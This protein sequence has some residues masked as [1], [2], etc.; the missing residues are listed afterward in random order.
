MKYY[1]WG[2]FIVSLDYIKDDQPQEGKSS[3]KSSNDKIILSITN[4]YC[5]D[6]FSAIIT[7]KDIESYSIISS[8][9]VLYNLIINRLKNPNKGYQFLKIHLHGKYYRTNPSI[10]VS[11]LIDTPDNKCIIYEITAPE[12][13]PTCNINILRKIV[14]WQTRN[15]NV[16]ARFNKY[17]QIN[18]ITNV[19]D[20]KDI[21]LKRKLNHK[22]KYE[23]SIYE[24]LGWGLTELFII[25]VHVAKDRITF[26]S[27]NTAYKPRFGNSI[28]KSFEPRYC[29]FMLNYLYNLEEVTIEDIWN[30]QDLNFLPLNN[31][32]KSLILID[33]FKLRDISSLCNLSK[34][35]RLIIDNSHEISSHQLKK[36][37]INNS[38]VEIIIV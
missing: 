5:L 27:R 22:Y 4:T 30:C 38:H 29:Q 32:I 21:I 36:Y 7:E 12:Y 31:T 17:P 24:P 20:L 19:D 28:D 8:L 3:G 14:I 26:V 1:Q 33:L 35:N 34:L 6:D 16:D 11:L 13:K 37:T 10:L 18:N 15:M 25:K 9:C 2:S 23:P